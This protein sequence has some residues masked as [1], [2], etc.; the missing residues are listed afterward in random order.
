MVLCNVM[1]LNYDVL[2][3]WL[4]LQG[5]SRAH[6]RLECDQGEYAAAQVGWQSHDQVNLTGPSVRDAL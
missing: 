2:S 4:Q 6:C 5:N 3:L 1:I